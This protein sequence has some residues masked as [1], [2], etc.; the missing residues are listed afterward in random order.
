MNSIALTFTSKGGPVLSQINQI[1]VGSWIDFSVHDVKQGE[2]DGITILCHPSTPN[3]PAPWILRS[4]E[5]S[6]QN[7]VFPGKDR[8]EI[9]IDKA[10]VLRYRLIIH[11]GGFQHL[12]MLKIQSD[13]EKTYSE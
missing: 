6:M 7:V 11:K 4:Y 8:V 2:I 12:D 13:Y 1:N 5:M 9:S 3:Y 10:T